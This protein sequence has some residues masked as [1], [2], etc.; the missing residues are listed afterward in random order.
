MSRRGSACRH[1]FVGGWWGADERGVRCGVRWGSK[2]AEIGRSRQN[3][4]THKAQEN[5]ELAVRARPPPPVPECLLSTG[6][7]VRVQHG[8]FFPG[9]INNLPTHNWLV[10]GQVVA[11]TGALG[12][13][14]KVR[15]Q[16]ARHRCSRTET[17]E[18]IESI[19]TNTTVFASARSGAGTRTK[20]VPA[21]ERWSFLWVQATSF[22]PASRPSPPRGTTVS[23]HAAPPAGNGGRPTSD[24]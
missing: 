24:S 9:E 19:E 18:L 15:D 14:S 1:G 3:R 17:R 22:S 20:Q 6:S 7:L 13:R 5:Q 12:A 23:P 4:T 11:R 10:L 21:V 16:T 2:A 8:S